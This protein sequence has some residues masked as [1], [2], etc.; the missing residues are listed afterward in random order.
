MM[1]SSEFEN[2]YTG[3]NKF[4]AN[5]YSGIADGEFSEEVILL[6]LQNEYTR[7]YEKYRVLKKLARNQKKYYM[8]LQKHVADNIYLL[9]REEVVCDIKGFLIEQIRNSALLTDE[10]VLK[11]YDFLIYVI[12]QGFADFYPLM[13]HI[14]NRHGQIT[15]YSHSDLKIICHYSAVFAFDGYNDDYIE[16]VLETS[17]MYSENSFTAFNELKTKKETAYSQCAKAIFYIM[18]KAFAHQKINDKKIDK[19]LFEIPNKYREE[20]Y[21]DLLQR[22]VKRLYANLV[23]FYKRG[24]HED[25][26]DLYIN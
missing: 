4:I 13:W 6:I 14:I 10:D 9:N 12:C 19:I 11:L 21:I 23:R 1:T 15:T 2:I 18:Q 26:Y 8:L 7:P 16:N 5:L 3:D 24:G 22:N 17:Y 20:L 25:I